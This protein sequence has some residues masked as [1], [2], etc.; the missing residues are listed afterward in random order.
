MFIDEAVIHVKGGKGGDGCISFRRE[1]FR[2]Y[3]G[4]DGGDGGD[5]GSVW[6]VS[7][8]DVKDLSYFLK[9][10]NFVAEDGKNGSSNNKHGK[11]G[12][13]IEIFVPAGTKVY[14]DDI[15]LF[16]FDAPGKKFCVAKGGRGGRGNAYFKS[17]FLRAP[18]FAEKGVKGEEFKIKL[19]VEVIADVGV[20]G[21]PNAGKSTMIKLLT[22]KDAKIGDYPFTTLEPL[23]GVMYHKGERVVIEEIPGIIENSSKGRGLGLKFLKHIRR[24]KGILF[25]LDATDEPLKQLKILKKEIKNYD[26][27]LLKKESIVVINKIDAVSSETLNKLQKTGYILV[28]LLAYINIDILKDE[29]LKLSKTK[30]KPQKEKPVEKEYVFE[31]D[32]DVKKIDGVFYITGNELLEAAQKTDFNNIHSI[33]RFNRILK[34]MGIEKL[35]KKN[36]IKDGDLVRIGDFEFRYF[37]GVKSK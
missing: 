36:G 8:S 25:L 13:D 24:V 21:F 20:V 32:V 9:K 37:T 17:N 16:D 6:I 11:K 26:K 35:L 33:E 10:K 12:R 28:S 30:Y 18:K 3:G 7:S 14:R 15:L 1:K 2:P 34:S 31:P 23:I 5:G 4:P 22:G 27:E 19:V 29:I